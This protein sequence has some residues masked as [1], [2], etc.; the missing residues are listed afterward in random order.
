V[1]IPTRGITEALDRYSATSEQE[2]LDLERIREAA[3]YRDVF[4]RSAELHVTASALVVHPSTRR[5]LLR[6]HPKMQRWMQVGGHF[7]PGETDPYAVALREAREETG[8]QDLTSITAGATPVQVVIVP[9]PTFGNEPAHEHADVRY[10]LTTEHP[11]AVTPENAAAR[12]RWLS[13]EDASAEVDEQNLRE[14]L[15]RAAAK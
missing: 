12:L 15:A 11:E 9:V 13:F 5:V 10:V 1:Q 14:F 4:S 2:G 3:K 8:L 6:W 7:D